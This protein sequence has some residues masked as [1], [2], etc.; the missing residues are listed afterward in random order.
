VERIGPAISKVAW[1]PEFVA[2]SLEILPVFE[3]EGGLTWLKPMHAASLRIGLPPTAKPGDVVVQ[4]L[5]RVRRLDLARGEAL[6]APPAIA[7][8]QVLEHALRHLSW[9]AQDD[10]AIR[11]ALPDWL[12]RLKEYEPEPFR[13]LG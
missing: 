3:G 10:P 7:A 6:G 9:L 8:E 2:Q 12:D 4:T 11:A 5:V 1:S 13:A